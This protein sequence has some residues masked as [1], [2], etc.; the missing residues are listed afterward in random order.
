MTAW[1]DLERSTA[2]VLGGQR[3][4]RGGDFS[5]SMADVEHPLLSIEAKYRAKLP[6]LLV[7]GMAQAAGYDKAKIPVL[8]VKE[9]Y[10]RGAL[11]V[12]R[13]KDFEDLFGDIRESPGP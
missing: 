9:R 13:L 5:Q 6:R 11:V 2:R 4:S 8:V 7:D 12:L 10:Q 1:K 3:N